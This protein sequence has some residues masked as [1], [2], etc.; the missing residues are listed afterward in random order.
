MNK[1][2]WITFNNLLK[3]SYQTE[4][5]LYIKIILITIEQTTKAKKKKKQTNV[6][7]YVYSETRTHCNTHTKHCFQYLWNNSFDIKM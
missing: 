6:V 2:M 7:S 5:H 1:K 3:I 4:Q